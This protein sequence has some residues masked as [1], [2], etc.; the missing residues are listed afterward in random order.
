L[1]QN[2]KE[3]K[4]KLR[5]KPGSYA[6]APFLSEFRDRRAP[7]NAAEDPSGAGVTGK[8]FARN[9]R[10]PPGMTKLGREWSA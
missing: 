7:A 2:G 1:P 9:S 5:A 8:S 6:L 4:Q 3:K 10:K